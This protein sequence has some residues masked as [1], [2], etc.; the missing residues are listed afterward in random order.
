MRY[1]PHH[2]IAEVVC[3]LHRESDWDDDRQTRGCIA[4]PWQ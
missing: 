3:G 1:L 4:G 2:C